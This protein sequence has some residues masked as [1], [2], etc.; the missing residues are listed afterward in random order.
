MKINS[1]G[2]GIAYITYV[3]SGNYFNSVAAEPANVVNAL[4]IDSVGNTYLSGATNDPNFPATQ[5]SYQ[6][7]LAAS[8]AVNAFGNP[9]SEA[10]VAKLASDASHVVWATYLGDGPVD[11]AQSIV[12]DDPSGNVWTTG[13]TTSVAF[14]NTNGWSTGGDFLVELNASG[15]ALLYAARY[16]DQTVAQAVALDPVTGLVHAAGA[17]GV[18]SGIAPTQTP[19]MRAFGLVSMAGGEISGRVAWGEMV[20]IYG[21]HIGPTVAVTATEDSSGALPTTLGGVQVSFP[22]QG[23][24]A[25]LYVSDSQINAILPALNSPATMQITNGGTTS[26]AFPVLSED[27]LPLVFLN[28]NGTAAA[29]NQDGTVNSPLNPAVAGSF[30]TIWATGTGHLPLDVGKIATS[31]N[32][33]CNSQCQINVYSEVPGPFVQPAT[34]LY[35]GASPGFASGFTEIVFLIPPPVTTPYFAFSGFNLT[36]NGFSSGTAGLYVASQ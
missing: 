28:A 16:P 35:A 33:S 30:V 34:V 17:T 20:S 32:N 10:F 27:A 23:N 5:G 21:P 22:D 9:L 11:A 1:G 13:T 18:V 8:T 14:P 7:T 25:L 19:T 15:A 36:V 26:P 24:A 12:V 2:T 31:A 6:P 3:G 4:A 29:V